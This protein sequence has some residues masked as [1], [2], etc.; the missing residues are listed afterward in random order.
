M[1]ARAGDDVDGEPVFEAGGV[2][3][4]TYCMGAGTD[5]SMVC[6]MALE[7]QQED[8]RGTGKYK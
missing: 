2:G 7:R 3:G 8:G 4:D 1:S 5:C 6:I